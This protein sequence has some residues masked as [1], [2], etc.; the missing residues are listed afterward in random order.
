MNR[1]PNEFYPEYCSREF[2]EW[3][4][5]QEIHD[6]FIELSKEK[7]DFFSFREIGLSVE[8]RPLWVAEISDS[9]I[10]DTTKQTAVFIA[11]EHGGERSATGTTLELIKWLISPDAKTLLE[12]QR[13]LIV[14]VVNVDAYE[15]NGNLVNRNDINLFADYNYDGSKPTQPEAQAIWNLVEKEKPDIFISLH[16]MSMDYDASGYH[17]IWESTSVA[18]TNNLERSYNRKIIDRINAAAEAEGYSM[19]LGAEDLER[20]LP[21]IPGNEFHSLPTFGHTGGSPSYCY[22]RFHSLSFVMEIGPVRSGFLRCREILAIGSEC[23][24]YECFPGYPNRIITSACISTMVVTAGGETARERRENRCLLWRNSKNLTTGIGG[25]NATRII[26]FMSRSK[27]DY[28]ELQ[29]FKNTG[30]LLEYFEAKGTPIKNSLE[31]LE[32][33]WKQVPLVWNDAKAVARIRERPNVQDF[34]EPYYDDNL[35]TE[36]LNMKACMRFR[37]DLE[38]TPERVL[39]NDKEISSKEYRTWQDKRFKYLEV[40]LKPDWLRAVVVIKTS[41]RKYKKKE[42]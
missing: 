38:V 8:Q 36:K 27:E 28:T 6:Y 16:G 34:P 17:R 22:N 11:T 29:N 40:D 21:F 13:I 4:T 2:T 30:A 1:Y 41:R 9:K 10:S 14:P 39:L 25:R 12:K 5:C 19:D 32:E 15:T 37:L 42:L 31:V 18:Y 24:E 35:G 33:E 20:C 3:P 23:W 7:S 26:G